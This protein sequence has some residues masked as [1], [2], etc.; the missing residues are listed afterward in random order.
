MFWINFS[1]NGYSVYV[2]TKEVLVHTKASKFC[3]R[4]KAHNP[5]IMLKIRGDSLQD[6]PEL[7]VIFQTKLNV[8]FE[9][10]DRFT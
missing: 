5:L 6:K 7:S 4:N 2:L 3:I 1:Y 8:L 9:K 10:F